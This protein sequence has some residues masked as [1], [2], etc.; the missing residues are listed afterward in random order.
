MVYYHY[1]DAI[2]TF[3]LL[4]LSMFTGALSILI[5]GK[6]KKYVLIIHAIFS[7]L[8]YIAFIITFLRA[9]KL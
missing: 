7:I 3:A 2:I 6:F 4:T 5:K 8:A 9:P 1:L